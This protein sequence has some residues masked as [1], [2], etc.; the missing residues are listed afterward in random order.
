MIQIE[1]LSK[2]FGKTKALEDVTVSLRANQCIAFVGPNGSGK[3][4]LIKCLLG[5]V[6]PDEGAILFNGASIL[7]QWAYRQHLG[8]MPQ[9]GRYPGQMRVRQVLTLIKQIRRAGS[10]RPIDEELLDA[11]GL[12]KILH[13]RMYTLSSGTRQKVGAAIA[14][15]YDP[16]VLILDEPTAGLDPVANEVLK[17]KIREERAKGKLLLISSHILSELDEVSSDVLFIQEGRIRFFKPLEALK[18]ETGEQ[19]LSRA[20]VQIMKKGRADE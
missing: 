4:T 20:I 18:A 9:V 11:F 8:Y 12:R 16:P 7:G 5:L 6:R 2:T 13:Q 15:L 1:Q 17:N 3:T 14:F 10:Q 19:R